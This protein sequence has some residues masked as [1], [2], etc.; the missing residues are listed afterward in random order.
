MMKTINR[1]KTFISTAVMKYEVLEPLQYWLISRRFKDEKRAVFEGIKRHLDK[2]Y[3]GIIGTLRRNVHRIEKGL[4]TRPEKPVYAESYIEET[5]NHLKTYLKKN[6]QEPSTVVWAFSVLDKYFEKVRN[7]EIIQR[8]RSSYLDIESGKKVVYVGPYR[9][10]ERTPLTVSYDDFLKLNERRRSVRYYLDK[11]VPHELIKK[12]M[13]A[14]L[15]SPSACN[16]QPF[17]F[18]VIDDPDLLK[19]A[20]E[21]PIGIGTF[22]FNIKMLIFVIG[23]LSYYFDERDKHL[24][25]IDSSLAA[26]NFVLSLETLGLSSCIINWA[27]LKER[28]YQLKKLLRLKNFER[29]IM[30]ISVGYADPN[31]G[32][33]ASL[34]KDVDSVIK[35]FNNEAE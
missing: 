24:I 5:V 21:L 16:R 19:R 2:E 1:I 12:A 34:K 25:Y 4:I 32:I 35:F 14:A 7:T 17:V 27:D 11:P 23:D 13:S 30:A 33:S 15:L 20:V 22:A 9:A 28:N 6:N 29:C 3:G 8:A 26:M 10:E 31:G 18:N